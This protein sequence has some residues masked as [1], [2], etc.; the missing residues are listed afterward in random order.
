M[1]ICRGILEGSDTIENLTAPYA[2]INKFMKDSAEQVALQKGFLS[3]ECL[4]G[5]DCVSCS[6]VLGLKP[7]HAAA[8]HCSCHFCECPMKDYW[9]AE[10]AAQYLQRTIIRIK[11]LAHVL[12]KNN[13]GEF[14]PYTCAGCNSTFETRDEMLAKP[15]PKTDHGV[16]AY[17]SE[18]FGVMPGQGPMLDMVEPIRF[19]ICI[20]H[21]RLSVVKTWW[22]KAIA[23]AMSQSPAVWKVDLVNTIL[24]YDVYSWKQTSAA[25]AGKIEEVSKHDLAFNGAESAHVLRWAAK[26]VDAVTLSSDPELVKRGESR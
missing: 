18:H 8:N 4:G 5:G 25:V 17:I 7:N 3:V 2:E 13:P 1:H 21:M 11:Q 6:S 23:E 24:E 20:L 9:D 26:L 16:A 12:G 15:L 22:K 19:I 10:K 14:E